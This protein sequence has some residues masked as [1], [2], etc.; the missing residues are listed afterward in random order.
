MGRDGAEL[1]FLN[2][3]YDKIRHPVLGNANPNPP[4]ETQSWTICITRG[5]TQYLYTSDQEPGR[6]YKLSLD[7]KILG[8][9]GESGH[10]SGQFNW[11]RITLCLWP[12]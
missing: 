12:I 4:D 5:A 9:L 10:E 3:P 2:A 1:L 7:G 11:I 8:V 6:I